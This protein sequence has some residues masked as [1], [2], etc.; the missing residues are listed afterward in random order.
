MMQFAPG[1]DNPEVQPPKT[2][3]LAVTSLI[4]SLIL[5][6]PLT[7]ILGPLLGLVSV[8]RIGGNPA[9][10]GRGI[11]V[12]AI[13]L[14]AIFTGGQF[15]CAYKLYA[16]FAVPVKEGPRAAMAA[17]FAG[18][19][20]GF[21]SGLFG[22]AAAASDGEAQAFIDELGRRYGAFVSCRLDEAEFERNPPSM[23]QMMKPVKPFP[24]V[25]EFENATVTADVEFGTVD[26]NTGRFL[27]G[28]KFGQIVVHD[29][30]LGDLTFPD[31]DWGGGSGTPPEVTPPPATLPEADPGATEAPESTTLPGAET[32]DD[33]GGGADDGG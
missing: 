31:P 2:S 8:I 7:T 9:L 13:L 22:D 18:D 28:V 1:L 23:E 15:W 32:A 17:G 24:Y 3:R 30:D 25:F 5:C 19:L 10:K 14:G 16:V 33:S 4:F 21:K 27:G 11:A 29:S 20:A 26:P 6:C 12:A